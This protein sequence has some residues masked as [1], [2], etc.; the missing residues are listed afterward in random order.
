M[1]EPISDELNPQV[2]TIP[3]ILRQ[4]GYDTTLVTNDQLNFDVESGFGRGFGTI[5][6]TT[7]TLSAN[8]LGTWMN[9]IDSI[10]A[11]NAKHRPAFVYFH[12]DHLHDYDVNLPNPPGSFPL[13]PSYVPPTFPPYSFTASTWKL[14]INYL[15]DTIQRSM[16]AS[17]IQEY[18]H[19]RAA[20]QQATS[21]HDAQNIFSEL[22]SGMQNDIY[23]TAFR[24]EIGQNDFPVFASLSR[25]LYDDSARTLDLALGHIITRIKSD[26]L[27]DNTIVVF[28]SDHGELL[29]EHG[30]VGHILGIYDEEI[31]IPLI[32]HVP[33]LDSQTVSTLAQHIDLLPTLIQLVGHAIPKGIAG[34][35]LLDVMTHQHTVG[36][37]SF[38]ISETSLPRPM[39]S[40]RTDTW[41]LVEITYPNGLYRGLYNIVTDPKETHS[42]ASTTQS[43]VNDLSLLLHTTLL[44]QPM[45]PPIPVSLPEWANQAD[46]VKHLTTDSAFK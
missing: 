40:I 32:V 42:V 25:H 16:I 14:T 19:W 45:Y 13:D 9:T 33:R 10:K 37:H 20:L 26:G 15:T 22:P 6:L 1:T 11:S 30:L 4:N 41:R 27:T 18:E 24:Q 31:H 44:R 43:V 3:K 29:G 39:K 7:P 38:I 35:S 46:R 17:D 21:L 5:Y 36:Q 12:T 23:L 2:T 34:T 8:T 28:T